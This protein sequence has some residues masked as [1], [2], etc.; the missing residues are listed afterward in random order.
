MRPRTAFLLPLALLLAAC[1]SSDGATSESPSAGAEVTTAGGAEGAAPDDPLAGAPALTPDLTLALEDVDN[2]QTIA[3]SPDGS[4]L[5]AAYQVALG[6][7]VSLRL[8]DLASGEMRADTEV[9]VL[10]I[11]LLHWMDD[12]RLVAATTESVG[13]SWRSWDGTS[14]EE[15]SVVPLDLSC[16]E[17]VVDTTTGMVYSV[18]DDGLCRVDTADG[19][20]SPSPALALDADEVWVRA[21]ADEVV[22]RLG[23][24]SVDGSSELVVL[25]G[26]TWEQTSSTTVP[27]TTQVLAVGT[28]AWLDDTATGTALLEPG[29]IPVPLIRDS[30]TVSDAGTVFVASIGSESLAFVSAVDGSVLGTVPAELNL[31]AFADWSADDAAFVRV[32]QAGVAEVY[33]F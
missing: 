24:D 27:A 26:T 22:V 17:G 31:S 18:T 7:P 33:T 29:A 16:G 14:L 8:Y 11:G 4:S 25:D 10:R 5:V 9:A 21:G 20:T 32:T 1:G 23:G 30:M 3:L 19:A 2:L 12:G 15:T 28:T 6:D 13:E